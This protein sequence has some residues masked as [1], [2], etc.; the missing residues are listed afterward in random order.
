MRNMTKRI[1]K[2][3]ALRL[4]RLTEGRKISKE[5]KIDLY[6]KNGKVAW[7]QG[8]QEYKYQYIQE[9][10]NNPQQLASFKK[11]SLMENYGVGIDERSVEYP[12]IFSKLS[13]VKTSFLD[14]GSTFNFDF[15]VEHPLIKKKEVTIYTFF[16]EKNCFFKNRINYVFGDLRNLYFK[17][18]CFDEIVCHSTIEHIDMDNSIYGYEGKSTKEEKSYDYLK[19]VSEMIRVLKPGGKL[20]LTFPFGKYEYHGFFQQFDAEMLNRIIAMFNAKGSNTVDY[21]KYEKK[22]WRFAEQLELNESESY[23]PHTG[24]GK[25]NDGA[26]HSRSIACLEFVKNK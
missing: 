11:K 18:A 15:L 14:A 17:D 5:E 25:G 16:P 8:Y 21:F 1:I 19:A 24:K 4:I 13:S 3:I 12:W 2:K 20:L 6:L 10:I 23:N 26:A 22:G 9:I 7:S